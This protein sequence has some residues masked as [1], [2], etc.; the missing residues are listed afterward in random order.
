MKSVVNDA[1]RVSWNDPFI[2]SLVLFNELALCL[3]QIILQGLL[4]VDDSTL[5]L[6]FFRTTL[7]LILWKSSLL[8]RP[9]V[10]LLNRCTRFYIRVLNVKLHLITILKWWFS[11]LFPIISFTIANIPPLVTFER[12]SIHLSNLSFRL[13]LFYQTFVHIE[14]GIY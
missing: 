13:V 5:F 8:W 10:L 1:W 2:F 6:L 3:F 14:N 7:F 11:Q 9:P 4:W 12:F